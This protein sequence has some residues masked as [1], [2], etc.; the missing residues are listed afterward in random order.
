MQRD[1][2]D[3]DADTATD[4]YSYEVVSLRFKEARKLFFHTSW[5]GP[6]LFSLWY[7][8]TTVWQSDGASRR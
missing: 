5:R 7:T 8:N 6:R 2:A 3:T 4:D 1:I